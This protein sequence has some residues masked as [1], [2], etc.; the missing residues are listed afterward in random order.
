MAFCS[1]CGVWHHEHRMMLILM[2]GS[3]VQGLQIMLQLEG[4]RGIFIVPYSGK[5]IKFNTDQ[6]L[7]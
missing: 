6:D 5:E 4:T 1:N 3:D 7:K 2:Q